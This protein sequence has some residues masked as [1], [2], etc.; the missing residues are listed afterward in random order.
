MFVSGVRFHS[1]KHKL[2]HKKRIKFFLTALFLGAGVVVAAFLTQTNVL[3]TFLLLGLL[4]L[5]YSG[6]GSGKKKYTFKLREIPYLKIFLISFIWSV[7]TILLPVIQAGNEI[8]TA[9][10]ILLLAERFLFIFA[11][12]IQFDI[13]DMKEDRDSGLKTIPILIQPQKALIV[14]HLALAVSFVIS[15]FHYSLQTNWFII[16]ALCIS[17]LTTYLFIKLQFFNNLE[18]YYYTILDGTLVLQGGLVLVFYL[19]WP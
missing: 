8:F 6:I 16:N 9:P 11:I 14:S 3:L 19:F 4:T 10:V 5:F 12:A 7:S 17:V 2:I 13:R 18:K 1:G 15:A